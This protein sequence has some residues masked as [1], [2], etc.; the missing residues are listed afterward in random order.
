MGTTPPSSENTGEHPIV[1]RSQHSYPGAMQIAQTA[2]TTTSNTVPPSPTATQ[3]N[4][5]TRNQSIK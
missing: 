3:V 1:L 5:I 2:L 4:E